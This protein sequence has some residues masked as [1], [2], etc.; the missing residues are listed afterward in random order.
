[1][2][3]YPPTLQYFRVKTRGGSYPSLIDYYAYKHDICVSV[4][5]R[6]ASAERGACI[7]DKQLAD[8]FADFVRPALVRRHG[9]ETVVE[10]ELCR[11]SPSKTLERRI[12]KDSLIVQARII[13]NNLAANK[14]VD[15]TAVTPHGDA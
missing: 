10:V 7:G 3:P 2:K 14:A 8:D 11:S 6:A 12:Q 15:L 13:T 9:K 4:H 1:M 5:A